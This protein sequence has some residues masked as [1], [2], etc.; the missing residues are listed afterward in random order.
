MGNGRKSASGRIDFDTAKMEIKVDTYPLANVKFK[1]G[2]PWG[3]NL[4]R[5]RVLATN[6]PLSGTLTWHI[7]R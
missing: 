6:P 7:T 4:Y 1:R 2:N 3:E 5:L